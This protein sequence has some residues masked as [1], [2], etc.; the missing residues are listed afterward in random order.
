VVL[1]ADRAALLLR[2]PDLDGARVWSV[3]P[4]A[5]LNDRDDSTG[6][7]D[8]VALRDSD[9]TSCDRVEYSAAGVAR[10]ITVERRA[11]GSWGAG[12]RPG[13]TPLSPPRPVEIAPLT[14]TAL[15]RRLRV[16]DTVELR[17]TLPWSAGEVG[18]ELYDL[19]GRRIAAPLASSASGAAGMH[20]WTVQ[21][22]APGIY[23]VALRA[24]DSL[25]ADVRAATQLLRI[26]GRV[27]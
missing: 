18:L 2:H 12:D 14:L 6:V 7:A 5:A 10:G 4:W 22:V 23:V 19:A 11:D 26:Q 16:G 21:D 20:R 24:H 9:G 15:P 8:V 13:G 25:G 17:W 27:P 1:A 3:T